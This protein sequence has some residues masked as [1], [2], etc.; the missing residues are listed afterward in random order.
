MADKSALSDLRYQFSNSAKPRK[1][2]R[3]NYQIKVEQI[4]LNSNV[5]TVSNVVEDFFH[6]ISTMDLKNVYRKIS[7]TFSTNYTRK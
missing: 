2:K 6:F 5:E 1:L 4:K 3:Y 7:N